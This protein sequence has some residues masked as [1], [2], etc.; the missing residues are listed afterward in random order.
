MAVQQNKKSRSRKGMRRSHDHVASPNIITCACGA[1][2][3]AHSACPTCGRYK[4]HQV[5]ILKPLNSTKKPQ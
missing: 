3:L 4:T 1:K 2:R 5:I